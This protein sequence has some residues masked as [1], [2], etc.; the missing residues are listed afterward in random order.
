MDSKIRN[1]IAIKKGSFSSGKAEKIAE[2]IKVILFLNHD[3]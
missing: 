2:I 1:F 3:M